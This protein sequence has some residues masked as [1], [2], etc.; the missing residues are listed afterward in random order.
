MQKY[1]TI[2]C[3]A[4]DRINEGQEVQIDQCLYCTRYEP[5][6]GQMYEIMNDL[7]T[8]VATIL[9]DNQMGN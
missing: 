4:D 5:I 7:G 6:A 2:R 1:K 3:L 8:N 9:D